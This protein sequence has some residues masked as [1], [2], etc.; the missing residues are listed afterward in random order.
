M[1]TALCHDGARWSE[2]TDLTKISDLIERPGNL[3]WAVVDSRR[4]SRK[5]IGLMAGE[6]DLHPLAVED[7]LNNRQRPKLETYENHLFAVMQQLDTV[8]GQLEATQ[9][10]CFVGQRYVM[11]LHNGAE[12]TLKEAHRRCLVNEKSADQGPSYVMHALLDAVVDDYQAISDGLE[13]EVEELEDILLQNPT[14]PNI[15]HRLYSLKQRLSRLR[16]YVIPGERVLATILQ[17]GRSPLITATTAAAFRDVHDHAL[18]IIDQVR[19]VDDL[20]EAV[21]NL[22]RSAQAQSLNDVTKRLTGWGAIIA[23]PTFIASVYGMNFALVPNEGDIFGFWFALGTMA[24]AGIGLYTY[25]KRRG[26]I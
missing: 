15:E 12:R 18:R 10:S 22:Q 1:L 17:P 4:L 23:V 20:V 25:F 8:N 16:R 26:W 13:I 6:L 3:V 5:D 2:V 19:N 24:A 21:I 9:I 11:T 14:V 7:S